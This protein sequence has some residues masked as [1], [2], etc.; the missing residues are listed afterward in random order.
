MRET[1]QERQRRLSIEKNQKFFNE[2]TK[3]LKEIRKEH[4]KAD[5]EK[6]KVV[7]EMRK[8]LNDSSYVLIEKDTFV[9]LT[10]CRSALIDLVGTLKSHEDTYNV[11][12]N[13]L[14]NIINNK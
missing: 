11:L 6:E 10:R 12:I 8:I 13:V 5:K 4:E 1:E 7:Q 9:H 2:V 3:G 14:T